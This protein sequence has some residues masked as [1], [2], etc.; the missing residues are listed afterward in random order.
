MQVCG[1]FVEQSVVLADELAA[2][3]LRGRGRGRLHYHRCCHGALIQPS[4]I[5]WQHTWN[6]TPRI[7]ET[8]QRTMAVTL[9]IYQI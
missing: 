5:R 8:P 9:N 4:A 6:M 3:A 1:R 2:D 7:T